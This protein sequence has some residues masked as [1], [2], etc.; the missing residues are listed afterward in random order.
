MADFYL[1]TSASWEEHLWNLFRDRTTV[2]KSNACI[3]Q[4]FT[5]VVSPSPLFS[6]T[7]PLQSSTHHLPSPSK[8]SSQPPTPWHNTVLL[9]QGSH[10]KPLSILEIAGSGREL[11]MHRIQHEHWTP[12][13][14]CILARC[15]F[16]S[17]RLSAGSM[18]SP[19]PNHCC[20]SVYWLSF[21][22]LNVFLFLTNADFC[23]MSGFS[24]VLNK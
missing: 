15:F 4:P 5:V 18:L 16:Q 3:C 22:N 1:S 11:H 14:T 12:V 20:H 21:H 9:L 17:Q 24:L 8:K 7:V 13:Q 2:R 6:V 19:F 23:K 10:S